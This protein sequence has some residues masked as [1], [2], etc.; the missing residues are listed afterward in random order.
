MADLPLSSSDVP[1]Y[2]PPGAEQSPDFL[3]MLS[4]SGYP[5]QKATADQLGMDAATATMPTAPTM[6]GALEERQQLDTQDPFRGLPPVD[7][8]NDLMAQ[9]PWLIGLAALGGKAFGLPAQAML[10]ATNGMVSGLIKGD[11]QGYQT[12][13]DK[14]D[15]EYARWDKKH[16]EVYTI[17]KSLEQSYKAQLGEYQAKQKAAQVAIQLANGTKGEVKQAWDTIH[18]GQQLKE[19]HEAT[20]KRIAQSRAAAGMDGGAA[21]EGLVGMVKEGAPPG[22]AVKGMGR[23]AGAEWSKARKKATQE[24]ADEMHISLSEAGA[25]LARRQVDYVAGRS[26]TTQMTKVLGALRPAVDQL[27]KNTAKA[28][29]ILKVIPSSDFSPILNAVA[30]GEE[31]WTGDPKY[32]SLFFLISGIAKEAARITSGGTLS[33]AQL[34]VQAAE[35]AKKWLDT[36]STPKSMIAPGGLFETL[37]WEGKTRIEVQ[38]KAIEKQRGKR[39]DDK[40]EAKASGKTKGD[41]VTISGDDDYS[42][43][44][45]GTFYKG[46]DGVTRQK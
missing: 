10:S 20:D 28:T 25:E 9:S 15:A 37:N 33:A 36:N 11:Q 12:E 1:T 29:E 24:I 26:S 42:A 38:E 22:S 46:P 31:E 27:D 14:Y 3:A 8:L 30:R 43:L 2:A 4:S 17:Y 21:D 16:T 7:H 5:S 19:H 6:T 45:K 41:P 35:E 44:A 18:S 39:D 23:I 34:N 32:S 13:K 40:P